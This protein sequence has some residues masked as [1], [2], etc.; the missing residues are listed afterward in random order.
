MIGWLMYEE[1]DAKL[2]KAFINI[3]IEQCKQYDIDLQ[4]HITERLHV[5]QL[6]QLPHFVWNRSRN[7]PLAQFFED[8]GIYVF[9]NSYTNQVANNKLLAQQLAQ[10]LHI[11]CIPTWT[12]LPPKDAFPIVAKT[13][14][15][16]G[17][18]EVELCHNVTEAFSFQTKHPHNTLFQP[19]IASN[20]QDV[21]IWVLGQRMIGA[22]KRTGHTSFKSNYTLGGTIEKFT[23]PAHLQQYVATL[24]HHLKSDYIG[25]DFLIG[26]DGHYYFNELEDPVGARSFFELYDTNLPQLLVQYIAEKG[27]SKRSI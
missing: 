2:N 20:S 15:G 26:M 6:Q 18:K 21:R 14:N 3:L 27:L 11:P 7:H 4:L 25:I 12:T 23:V 19:F 16:H 22:V 8:R 9:N 24:T 1:H 13:T 10:Q 5:E 17:G